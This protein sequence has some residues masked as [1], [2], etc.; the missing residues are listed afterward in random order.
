M[1]WIKEA[2]RSFKALCM[3]K[4]SRSFMQL[5]EALYIPRSFMQLEEVLYIPRSFMQLEEALCILKKDLKSFVSLK[6]LFIL[7]D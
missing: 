7:L 4:K 2:K 3:S 1:N 5:E 6:E